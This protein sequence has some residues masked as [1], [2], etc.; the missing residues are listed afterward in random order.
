MREVYTR[1]TQVAKQHLYQFM[2]DNGIS[3]LK[4]RFDYYF[5]TCVEVHKI[6][7]LEH[8]FSNH[9]IEG[10][11][12]IDD[13]GI[14]F[15]YEKENPIV[16]QNFTKCHELGHFILGHTGNIFTELSDGS[17]SLYESEANLFSA[18]VLMPDIVLLSMIYYRKDNFSKLLTNLVISSEALIYRLKDLF[19]FYLRIDYQSITQAIQDYR[20]NNKTAILA[21]F[22]QVKDRIEDGY[23][24][25]TANPVISVLRQLDK[26]DFISSND[27]PDLLENDFRK[28][29][30]EA[31]SSIE[32]WADFD[33]GKTIGYAWKKGKLTQKQAQSRAKTILLLETR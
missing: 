29:L 13:N 12:M 28:Q 25:V 17:E 30:E 2:K 22:D 20:V 9:K 18:V 31:D 24:D 14:S 33:F 4:Y 27:Y 26:V 1:V 6:K 19:R 7:V 15:S 21:L 11:T 8:H 10:L 3:P 5:D 23:R 16:K 32:S